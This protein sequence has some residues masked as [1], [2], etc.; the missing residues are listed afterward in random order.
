MTTAPA[1]DTTPRHAVGVTGAT[2]N[3]G[4]LV[5]DQL[6][7]ESAVK[8]VISIARDPQKAAPLKAR[9]AAVRQ[10]DYALPETLVPALQ[11]VTRL[12]LISGSDLGQRV[13]QHRAV[14]DAAKRAN[15]EFIAYTS[16]LRADSSTLPIAD[17]HR[18]TEAL[19]RA[20]GLSYAIL[21]NGWYIENYTERLAMPLQYGAFIG[22]AGNGRIAAAARADYAAAAAR[23]LVGEGHEGKTYELTG[24]QAFTMSE[25]AAAVSARFGRDIPY[26]NLP[27]AQFRGA[28]A[29]AG[30]PS[31]I[32]DLLVATDLAIERGD[33]DRASADLHRLIGRRSRT[34]EDVLRET[35]L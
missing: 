17:E 20:S 19:L 16:V 1:K 23:V 34:L 24:D 29:H 5:V 21:R 26:R 27:D 7:A 14:I 13:A 33:L 12:L 15:V 9:G 3:L 30:L 4:E 31:E 28:L 11:G 8:D 10:G 25:L 35:T 2:G 6:L 22:A 32:V 18:E